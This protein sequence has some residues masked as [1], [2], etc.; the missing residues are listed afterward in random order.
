MTTAPPG[1]IE[2][3]KTFTILHVED[4]ENDAT[5]LRQ[6]LT[7]MSCPYHLE[8]VKDMEHAI[9]YLSE[10]DTYH[11]EHP[12]PKVVLCDIRMHDGDGFNFLTWVRASRNFGM[13]PVIM[14]SGSMI[15][16]EWQTALSL[17]ATSYIKKDDIKDESERFAHTIEGYADVA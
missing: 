8:R 15:R 5:H 9:E 17:G 13:L 6:T 12:I 10:S 1:L 11:M 7:K 2:G 16:N 14:L 4:N 3:L